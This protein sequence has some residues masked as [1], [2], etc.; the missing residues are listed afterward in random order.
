MSFALE[1]EPMLEALDGALA[2]L[3]PLVPLNWENSCTHGDFPR[4][5]Q[6]LQGLPDIEPQSRDFHGSLRIGEA[7]QL[8]PIDSE[9]LKSTLMHL[10][11][12]R[13][14]PLTL[15]GIQIDTE[16]RSDWKWNR[17][18]PHISPLAGRRVLDVGCGNGYH[19]WRMAGHEAGLVLGIE[20]SVLFNLQFYVV[21]KY[22]SDAPVFLLPNK[23]EELPS[24]LHA[25]D[26]VFSMGVLY[27]RR[28]PIEHL[29]E[30]RNCLQPGGELVLETLMAEGED[31]FPEPGERY[32]RMGNIWNVPCSSTLLDWMR[33]AGFTNARLV[34][35]NRTS[36]EEQRSTDW[37]QF[38]SLAQSLD[39]ND[40]LLTVEGYPAPLRGIVVA[41]VPVG[42]R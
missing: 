23:L 38:E 17:V 41:T 22:C 34:D 6:A 13:K 14:G 10:H 8:D 31:L 5:Y 40:Q 39:P 30:L 19:C 35:V 36:T 20:P 18:L 24:R 28:E 29:E 42:V 1:F 12:W 32:A 7:S 26:T 37:M 27:H 2:P 25:F 33:E 16:W 3:R 4:W 21:K 11:P 15:F 9:Q